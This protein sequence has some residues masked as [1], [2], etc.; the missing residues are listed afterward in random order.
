MLRRLSGNPTVVS[1]FLLLTL[2]ILWYAEM[3]SLGWKDRRE[4]FSILG[5]LIAAVWTLYLFLLRGSFETSL[6]MDLRVNAE[7]R[8]QLYV[9]YLQIKLENIGGRRITA[10]PS[11]SSA[12]IRDYEDSV[13]HPCDLQLRLLGGETPAARF[14]GW[15]SKHSTLLT[16]IPEVPEHISVLYEYTRSDERIDFFMEP[17]EKYTLGHIFIL[18]PGH[19]VAKLVFVGERATAAEY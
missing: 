15:W 2:A 3:D 8:D 12:Q 4:A 13:Q 1:V 19:Y 6:A 16:K 11:L 18:P 17:R 9:V 7:P 5:A 10:P 14:V